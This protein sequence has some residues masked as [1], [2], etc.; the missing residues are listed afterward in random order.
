MVTNDSVAWNSRDGIVGWALNGL[1]IFYGMSADRVDPY[2][3]KAW[4]G[5]SKTTAEIVDACIGHPQGD[6]LYHYHMLPPCLVNAD[7]MQTTKVCEQV[8]DC[9]N[10]L[11]SY[12]MSAFTAKAKTL[13][14][15][16]VAKDGR[17][18]VGP[19]NSDGTLFDCKTLD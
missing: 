12:A 18:I 15:I 13:T 6:N 8:A 10:D 7:N 5:S 17:P 2:Y 19:Y 4:S 16:G 9:T 11:K 1:P 3:P 14:Y